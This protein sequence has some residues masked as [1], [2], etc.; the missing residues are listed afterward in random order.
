MEAKTANNIVATTQ[1]LD[2]L[3]ND[4]ELKKLKDSKNYLKKYA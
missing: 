4:A 1:L 2:F 3:D